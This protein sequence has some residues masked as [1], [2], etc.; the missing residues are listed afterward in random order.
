MEFPK[1]SAEV[2]LISVGCNHETRNFICD[3]KIAAPQLP[4]QAV[5]S[6][7]RDRHR[8]SQQQSSQQDTDFEQYSPVHRRSRFLDTKP[9]QT[10]YKDAKINID[11]GDGKNGDGKKEGKNEKEMMIPI[12]TRD[13]N[14]IIPDNLSGLAK[15]PP[16]RVTELVRARMELLVR[17]YGSATVT[18]D[19]LEPGF[20]PVELDTAN[21][22]RAAMQTAKMLLLEMSADALMKKRK[23]SNATETAKSLTIH[24]LEEGHPVQCYYG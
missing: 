24:L 12:S 2:F 15:I 7:R 19:M 10:D 23:G 17:M 11:N 4:P 18:G 22:S 1:D 6:V 13:A 14:Q 9:S 3:I 21:I 16:V 20:L 5:R 8:P